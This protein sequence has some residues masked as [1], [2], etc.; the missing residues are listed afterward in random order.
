M[1]ARSTGRCEPGKQSRDILKKGS[2]GSSES[3]N[4]RCKYPSWSFMDQMGAA[5]GAR[6]VG[7]NETRRAHKCKSTEELTRK[8]GSVHNILF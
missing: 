6:H 4:Q 3:E 8:G 1:I 5:L 7:P 2:R